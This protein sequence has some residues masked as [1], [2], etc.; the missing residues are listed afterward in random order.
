M[1]GEDDMA[2][3]HTFGDSYW[4]A[5]RRHT[6]ARIALGRH[7]VSVPTSAQLAFQ[8]A[9]HRRATPGT[10]RS[11]ARPWHAPWQRKG[12]TACSC[13]APPPRA[14]SICSAPTWDAGLTTFHARGW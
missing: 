12:K 13:T 2:D 7:G 6:A 10:W 14:P 8:L 3:K 5:L 4:Q 9:T 11:M 1:R